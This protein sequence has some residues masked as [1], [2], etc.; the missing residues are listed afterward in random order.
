[1]LITK[2]RVA[3]LSGLL[4]VTIVAA[5]CGSSKTATTTS[6]S[7][8]GTTSSSAAAASTSAAP[9]TSS[10][11][12]LSATL[13]SSGSTFVKTFL[14]D[15]IANFTKANKDVTINFAGGGSGKGRQDLADQ[16]TEFA[17]S[18]SPVPAA[19]LP[20]F[21]GGAVLYF[22]VVV[23]P[24]TLAYNLSGVAKLQLSADT[25]AK[26]FQRQI[27]AWNAPAIAAENTGVTLPS[28][29]IVV[30]VRSD[31]SGTT[32]NFTKFLDSAA[33][34]TASGVWTLKSGS[35]ITWPTDVQAGN[36]NAGVAQIVKGTVGAIGYVDY[37]DAKAAGLSFATVKNKAGKYIDAT[38]DGASA[39]ADGAKVADNLTFSAVWAD[40]D[41]AYPI[42]AQTWI[43]VYTNQT[44]KAKGAAIAAFVKYLVT[45]GQAL[46]KYD[47]YSP[48]PTALAAKAATQV[49][50]IVLPV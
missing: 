1:M 33:G 5:A 4:A 3:A 40:G 26:I 32:A 19:D 36:G 50:S 17:G 13:N 38:L 2:R 10:A 42:T 14:E 46:A 29:P 28:T 6:S 27:K 43:I 44:D 39:A 18:D 22:P 35:T 15:A 25:I 49:D 8:A 45:D 11:R 9:T 48:L 24:I 34:A 30:A 20:K 47:D 23:A 7:A 16:L 37:S 21:K 31:S 41:G 12:A